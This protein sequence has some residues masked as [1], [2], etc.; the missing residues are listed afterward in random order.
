MITKFA[1]CAQPYGPSASEL[2][3]GTC[4]A[5]HE[6]PAKLMKV[7]R[8]AHVFNPTE[9]KKNGPRQNPGKHSSTVQRPTLHSSVRGAACHEPQASDARDS[10]N[11]RSWQWF[12]ARSRA[13]AQ[14]QGGL[15]GRFPRVASAGC[16]SRAQDHRAPSQ[17]GVLGC[18]RSFLI[19][20]SARQSAVLRSSAIES[21]RS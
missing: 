20:G 13:I 11:T 6:F 9:T 5:V 12:M 2:G 19:N 17:Q 10:V 7:T 1:T 15:S 4:L 14:L 18:G 8:L 16:S 3:H 21:A